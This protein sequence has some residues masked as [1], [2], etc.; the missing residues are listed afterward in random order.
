M[1][2]PQA[3][4][5]RDVEHPEPPFAPGPV[6]ELLR[7]IVK[8]ARAQQL[9]LPNNPIYK[10]AIDAVRAAFA[11]IWSQTDELPLSFTESD[12]R[13]FD[14]PVLNDASKSSDSLPWLFYKDGIRDLWLLKGL[15][16]QELTKLLDV[17]QRA[18]KAGPEDDDLLTMLWEADLLCVKY[19]Y[20]DLTLE[21]ASPLADGADVQAAQPSEIQQAAQEAVQESRAAGVVNM[22]DFD[23]TL[24]FLD[25]KEIEYL[26]EEVKRE[27]QEDLRSKIIVG[28]LDIFEQQ[29][30]NEVRLEV[31][32]HL[33]TMLVFLLAAGHFRGVTLMLK[34]SAAA[35]QR[36]ELTQEQR[37]R[38]AQLPGRLSAPEAL[39][40]LM[41]SLDE[42]AQL[43]VREE[44]AELFEQFRPGALGTMLS[45]LGRLQNARLRPLLEQSVERLAST[46]TTEL[47][48]LIGAPERDVACE[49]MRRSGALK[50]A[51][52][53]PQLAK[54]VS[55]ADPELRQVAVQALAEIG[56][57][58]ALQALERAVEDTDREVRISALRALSARSY[59]PVL[60]R[61]ENAVK[62]KAIRDAD[63]TEKMAFFEAYGALCGDSGVQYL[64]SLLNGKGFLGKREEAEIRACAAIALGR[65]GT[66]KSIEALQKASGEKDVVVRNAVN[67]ALRGTSA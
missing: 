65:V 9:Y 54:I 55:S 20:V 48:R 25:E 4:P 49:A 64:D 32:E 36:A 51:A 39:S 50:T 62:G 37:E 42:A 46:A 2:S 8:A 43:P 45:W 67:R 24:Y 3:P 22:A 38:L 63:L 1:T 53:V 18:R 31:L 14:V 30:D 11:P 40:Q 60:P 27:Y 41:Q 23:S 59:R 15:E 56:S 29:S 6:E 35:A 19:R 13:W 16:D 61:L 26:Q 34:E 33:D 58:G 12:I 7:V 47:V 52:A 5:A 28:L 57:P 21:P 66:P 17:L 10:A 44:L